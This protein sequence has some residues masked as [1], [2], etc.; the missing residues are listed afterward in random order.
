MTAFPLIY[1]RVNKSGCNEQSHASH[2]D[3]SAAGDSSAHML[4]SQ[5]LKKK[6]KKPTTLGDLSPT[7][8]SVFEAGWKDGAV[9]SALLSREEPWPIISV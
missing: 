9:V 3:A 5:V 7:H 1:A 8:E 2:C 4:D 6:Q